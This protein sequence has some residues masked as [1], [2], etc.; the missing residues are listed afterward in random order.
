MSRRTNLKHHYEKLGEAREIVNS[1]KSLSFIEVRRVSQ[2]LDLQRAVVAE[3]M[4][5]AMDYSS[6]YPALL[7]Q[8]R[9]S[10]QVFLVVGAERGFCGNFN[11]QL[12]DA[13]KQKISKRES[14]PSAGVAAQVIGVG[15]KLCTHLE[16]YPQLSYCLDGAAVADEVDTCLNRLL[17][18]LTDVF[19]SGANTGLTAIYHDLEQEHVVVRELLPPFASMV[20]SNTAYS[21]PPELYLQPAEF[22]LELVDHYL[23]AV[24]HEI[25]YVSL[26]AENH[27][28]MQHLEGAVRYLDENMETLRRKAN[29]QRQEEITEEIEVILLSAESTRSPPV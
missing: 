17:V 5:V 13:L 22:L 11:E 16:G 27:Q 9:A 8:V 7:P 6:F 3:I 28:R 26:M 21:S 2:S 10:R 19:A 23:Y 12:L 29:Q 20:S 15:H 25:L 14:L 24:L 18:T 1:M 4:R